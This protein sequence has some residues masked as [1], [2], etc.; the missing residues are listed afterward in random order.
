MGHYHGAEGFRNFS[1]AKGVVRKGRFN[2]TALVAPPWN[3]GMYRLLQKMQAWRFRRR[4]L[5]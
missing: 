1:K 3:N 4:K 5:R 2:A